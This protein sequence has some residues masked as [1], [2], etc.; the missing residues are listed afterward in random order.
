LSKREQTIFALLNF[1]CAKDRLAAVCTDIL[2]RN[3]GDVQI[4]AAFG[5]QVSDISQIG[6]SWEIAE[7][8]LRYSYLYPEKTILTS[9]EILDWESRGVSFNRLLTN[10][11][12]NSLKSA[13]CDKCLADWK[14]IV[15]TIRDG[16]YSFHEVTTVLSSCIAAAEDY[17]LTKSGKKLSRDFLNSTA[18]LG[19]LSGLVAD[20]IFEEFKNRYRQTG[21]A[22]SEL[23]G[24]AK[25]YIINNLFDPQL[26]L[27][28]V[29]EELGVS[30]NYRSRVFHSECNITF[31]EYITNLKLS[32]S[33]NLVI[34]SD[35]KI[36]EIAER[37][38][39]S[40][41]Q[42]FISNFKKQFGVTPNVYRQREKIHR[43]AEV[44]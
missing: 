32:Y 7:N 14:L 36:N 9:E 28:L 1:E 34:N 38:G 19:A 41:A 10:N 30:A 8:G 23:C 35:L 20:L 5:T 27:N 22:V 29:A 11:F 40:T 6:S 17:L 18:D 4:C 12:V 21:N 3:Y 42:Y 37:L 24:A 15:R 39:Y 44:E 31:V 26:S 25:E 2:A 33:R 16:R 13:N 43:R